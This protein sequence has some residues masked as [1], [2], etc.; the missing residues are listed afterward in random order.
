MAGVVAE[1][2]IPP[3]AGPGLD[4]H[5]QRPAVGHQAFGAQ[6]VQQRLE[7]DFDWRRDLDLFADRK[8]LNRLL[9]GGESRHDVPLLVLGGVVVAAFAFRSA[10]SLMRSSWKVQNRS[11]FLTQSCT[12]FNSLASR[13]YRRCWP[14]LATATMPTLRSTPRC[15][16]T[17]GCGS[18]IAATRAPTASA[19]R[20]ANSS[21]ICRRRGSAMALKTSAVVG[22]RAMSPLYSRMGICRIVDITL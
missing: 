3:P 5:L 9:L 8:R 18:S 14:C 2:A 16:D 22:A 17:A 21:M 19:P 11:K 7:G 1:V 12:G 6:L 10:R 4:L 20:P 13:R 15:F